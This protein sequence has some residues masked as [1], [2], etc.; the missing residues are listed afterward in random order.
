[1]D[2]GIV[3]TPSLLRPC[4]SMLM[5]TLSLAGVQETTPIPNVSYLGQDLLSC[6][7]TECCFEYS[8]IQVHHPISSYVEGTPFLNFMKEIGRNFELHKLT[9]M[10]HCRV[11]EDNLSCI[12]VAECPNSLQGPN[13]LESSTIILENIWQMVE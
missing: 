3:L 8:R 13:T 11:F 1:M 4:H 2:I 10:I 7:Q 12:R 6:M 9:P 5:W